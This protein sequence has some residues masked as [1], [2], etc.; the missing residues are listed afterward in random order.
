MTLA[1]QLRS[2]PFAPAPLTPPIALVEEDRR[3]RPLAPDGDI[4]S[5]ERS[6]DPVGRRTEAQ[7][8]A[9]LLHDLVLQDL[10]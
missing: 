8:A 10:I 9:K 7:E 5:D 6:L 3:L 4:G 2:V 1:H